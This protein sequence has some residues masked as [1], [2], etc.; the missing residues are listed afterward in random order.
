MR[1]LK[2]ITG[3]LL[4]TGLLVVGLTAGVTV[5]AAI[6]DNGAAVTTNVSEYSIE[7]M[8][9]YATEQEYLA[10]A[11]YGAIIDAYGDQRPFSNIS[12]AKATHISLLE[13]LLVNYNYEIQTK[14]WDS[15]VAVPESIKEAYEIGVV[16][17]E[18]NIAMYESFLKEDLPEE[19]RDVF[20]KLINSSRKHLT[21]FQRQ[22]DGTGCDIMNRNGKGKNRQ[23]GVNGN[24]GR[25]NRK[26]NQNADCILP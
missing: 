12:N 23:G 15:L 7:K 3:T 11:T 14:D 5:N 21:A 26:N 20:E 24:F 22:V 1:Q 13:S 19:V 10:R 6:S 8:I 9:A 17:E 25:G 4:A 2:K 16:N 18:K